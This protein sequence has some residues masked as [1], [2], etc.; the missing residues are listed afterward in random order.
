MD[1]SQAG[2]G[3]LGVVLPPILLLLLLLVVVEPNQPKVRAA[4]CRSL[5]LLLHAPAADEDYNLSA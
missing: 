1:G 5:L 3:C 2:G 4:H